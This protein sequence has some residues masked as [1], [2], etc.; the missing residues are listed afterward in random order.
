MDAMTLNTASTLM[1]VIFILMV[2]VIRI[3]M[4]RVGRLAETVEELQKSNTELQAKIEQLQQAKN[5]DAV[6]ALDALKERLAA[7]E[8]SLVS[9]EQSSAR[10]EQQAAQALEAKTEQAVPAPVIEEQKTPP[11]APEPA[12][13][14]IR[15]EVM[16]AI[17]A[18]VT[19]YGY[20]LE[21]IRSIKPVRRN[22]TAWVMAG[23]LQ[24]MGIK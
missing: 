22:H 1:F 10:A 6:Q 24:N 13:D 21:S 3:V 8:Q 16:A 5:D 15:P 17:M 12:E 4:R 7:I 14:T 9:V 2:L 11:A 19:A 20:P 23:R 18:A